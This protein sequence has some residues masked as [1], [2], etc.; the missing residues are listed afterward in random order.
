MC[1]SSSMTSVEGPSSHSS[2]AMTPV[3]HRLHHP[4]RQKLFPGRRVRRVR[5]VAGHAPNVDTIVLTKTVIRDAPAAYRRFRQI[6]GPRIRRRRR[7]PGR[8]S[9]P[10]LPDDGRVAL[11]A[12]AVAQRQAHAGRLSIDTGQKPQRVETCARP[13]ANPHD[14]IGAAMTGDAPDPGVA[15][16][17]RRSKIARRSANHPFELRLVEMTRDAKP[18]IALLGSKTGE[19][20]SPEHHR[21][22]PACHPAQQRPSPRCRHHRRCRRFSARSPSL[23]WRIRCVP[24][25][26]SCRRE[27]ARPPAS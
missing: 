24:S 17:M 12:V 10:R 15:C 2:L 26:R 19:K 4:L 9:R 23:A 8:A 27:A 18:V 16:V 6:A 1:S 20:D 3:A 14:R 21:A 7:R 13:Y 22:D 25:Y 11:P 5:G